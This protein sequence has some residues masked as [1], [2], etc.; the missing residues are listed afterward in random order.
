MDNIY[1]T[2][3]NGDRELFSEEKLRRSIVR[4][5]IPKEFEDKAVEY[6]KKSLYPEIRTME[7][8]KSI[9]DF[10][11]ENEYPQGKAKYSL[12]QA[13]ME[14]GPTGFPFEKFI[15]HV[16]TREG[17]KTETDVPVLGFCISHEVDVIAQKNDRISLIECKYHNFPGT[18]TGAKI[19]LYVQARFEDIMEGK[20][21]RGERVDNLDIWLATNTKC[22]FDAIEYAVCR[23]MKIISWAYPPGKSLRDI[24]ENNNYHPITCLTSLNRSEKRL[25]LHK[26]IVLC[27]DLYENR[28]ELEVMGIPKETKDEVLKELDELCGNKLVK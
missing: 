25:L 12:K 17:Y 14:L 7:I 26:N 19:V 18:I 1:V 6:V 21:K 27:R 11:T 15:A 5:G 28:N 23:K 24:L 10:F 4:A 22:S 9:T 2:K 16:M 20:K 3:A 8:F 13:I